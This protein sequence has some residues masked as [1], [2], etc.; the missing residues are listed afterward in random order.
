MIESILWLMDDT[1]KRRL[2]SPHGIAMPKG[3]Y[4]I[5][6]VFS[7]PPLNL[8]NFGP[9]T[10]EKGWRVFFF[11]SFFLLFFAFDAECVRSLNGSQPKLGQI[12]TYDCYLKKFGPNSPGQL[13]LTGWG[14]KRF[15]RPT[16]NFDRT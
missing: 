9:E 10:A 15:L 14:Q 1:L 2:F 3:L 6:V 16:L 11:P 4:F 8:V 5:A 7:L 13:P 12:F